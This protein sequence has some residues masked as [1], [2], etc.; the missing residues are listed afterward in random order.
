M[1]D[2][3]AK[4]GDGPEKKLA[5]A[6]GGEYLFRDFA[7]AS[8]GERHMVTILRRYLIESWLSS[9]VEKSGAAN[10]DGGPATTPSLADVVEA[11]FTAYAT[12][13]YGEQ[14]ENQAVRDSLGQGLSAVLSEVTVDS[15][16]QQ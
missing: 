16:N 2:N 10:E 5:I 14:L 13:L 11:D 4:L 7:D 15:C 3:L 8:E 9:L 12:E 6:K 1:V